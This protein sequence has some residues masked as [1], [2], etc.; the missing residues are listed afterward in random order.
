MPGRASPSASRAVLTRRSSR[1]N[2][3]TGVLSFVT[4]PDFEVPT[5]AG[6]NNV[7]DVIVQTSDG[8]LI[9]TQAIAVTVTNVAGVTLTGTAAADTL[10][11][12]GEEDTLSG[13]G[14]NDTLNGLGGNDTLLGG[15]GTDTLNGG[16]GADTLIGGIGNDVLN[17]GLGNDTFTYTFGDGADT[18]AGGAGFDT[19]NIIGT[20]GNNVLDVIFNGT[21]ITNFEGGTITGVEAINAD[22]LAGTDTLTY[23]GTTANVTVNLATSSA[24]GFASIT[25]IENVVGGSGNDT[26]IGDALVN[27]LNGGVGNDTL[28]G[29]LGNDTLVG[30]LGDDTYIANQGDTLTEAAGGG[31]DS[32]FTASNAFTLANNVENLTFTGVGNF[33]GTGNGVDNVITGGSGID[34]LSGGGGADTLIGN[35]GVNSLTGGAGNDILIGGAGN[36]VMNGG[37]DND[38]FV[39]AAGFGND[40]ISGFD[41]NP[42]G[43]QDLLDISG[44][45][46]TAANFA[47][48]VVITDLGADTLRRDRGRHDLAAGCQ[49]RGSERHHAA[50]LPPALNMVWANCC[51]DHRLKGAFA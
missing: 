51:V 49:R 7:Y 39:F 26:L 50:G 27:N 14:G 36:D 2:P 19:L 6:A 47:T 25:G 41:A 48:S 34:V 29:G 9:D 4:A 46:I 33:T 8:S 43:G 21:S 40:T 42:T 35:G 31:T 28:D 37:T 10:N 30:G 18:V 12:T 23:A 44:L 3:T 32:V 20:T 15:A 24:S 5:D 45:G 1:I 22:L 38:T 11:G 17:G 16:D 13:L